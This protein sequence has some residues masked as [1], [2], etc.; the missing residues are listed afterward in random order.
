MEDRKKQVTYW[1]LITPS[2]FSMGTILKTKRC[3]KSLASEWLLVKNSNMPEDKDT[4]A[5]IDTTASSC[6]DTLKCIERKRHGGLIEL[7]HIKLWTVPWESNKW[8]FIEVHC[9]TT[10]TIDYIQSQ[11]RFPSRHISV[12]ER[13]LIR[14]AILLDYI[15]NTEVLTSRK[16]KLQPKLEKVSRHTNKI[17][18][19]KMLLTGKMHYHWTMDTYL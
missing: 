10:G 19:W 14:N 18:T 8:S 6:G 13:K 15:L 2:G 3:R 4:I 12:E 11:T 5:E 16:Y 9:R 17:P 7:V 1:P